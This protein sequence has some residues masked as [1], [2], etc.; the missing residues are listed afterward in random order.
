MSPEW[1]LRIGDL[2]GGG[3]GAGSGHRVDAHF[4]LLGGLALFIGAV[5]VIIVVVIMAQYRD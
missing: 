2:S 4:L 5:I 1:G 3:A